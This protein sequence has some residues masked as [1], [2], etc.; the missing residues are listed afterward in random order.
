M[1][2]GARAITGTSLKLCELSV[3]PRKQKRL[4]RPNDVTS[5]IGGH[6]LARLRAMQ[7]EQYTE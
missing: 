3:Q 1:P 2:E 6:R 7:I 4:A 5:H